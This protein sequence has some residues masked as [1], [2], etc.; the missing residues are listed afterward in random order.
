MGTTKC[1]FSRAV[2][3]KSTPKKTRGFMSLPA[4]LRNQVYRYYFES[5]LRCEVV[6]GS[7]RLHEPQARTVKLWAG[8]FHSNGQK[9]RYTSKPKEDGPITLRTPL[10]LGK[11]TVVQGLQTNWTTSL[12]ALILVCKQVYYETTPFLYRKT[13]FVFNAPNRLTNFLSVVSGP[14][15][16]SITTLQLHYVTYGC[17]RLLQDVIWQ[18]KHNAAWTRACSAASKKLVNLRSL[19]IWMR[20]NYDPLK[21]NLREPWIQPLL[22]FRR[23]S[24]S[25]AVPEVVDVDFKTRLSGQHFN[26]H[27][28]L[29]KA[30]EDLHQ[31]FGQA[32]GLAISGEK[33]E[34][35]MRGF[36]EAWK[37]EHAI[38]R[39]H[40]RFA[41]T[42]W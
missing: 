31:L 17:P 19:K 2:P 40:L 10:Q 5:D 42:G 18:E 38:W 27:A 21:F 35:A 30:N 34:V 15:L 3:G 12:C 28:R 23:L 7:Q 14:K 1:L 26:G 11:Y 6:A 13:T 22:Q 36:N 29:A 32:V 24:R 20:V 25:G 39:Y 4:E 33:E 9:L 41:E 37:G 16:E 8:A